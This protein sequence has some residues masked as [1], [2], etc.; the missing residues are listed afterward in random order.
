MCAQRLVA[1]V[2][3]FIG[4]LFFASAASTAETALTV[5]VDQP[6]TKISPTLYGIFFE[7]INRAGEGGL[8][9][10][11]LQNRS[12]E[13]DRG[14]RDQKPVKIPGWSL[15]ESPGAKATI[16]LDHSE[17]LN[18]RDPNSLRLEIAAVGQVPVGVANEGFNGLALVKGASYE[19]SFYARSSQGM[20]GPLVATLED[21]N[22]IVSEAKPIGE[23]GGQWKQYHETLTAKET[24][25]RGRLVLASSSSGTIW[26]DEVSLFPKNTWKGRP[27]GLRPDLAKMLADLKPAFNRFPGGCYVEGNR[28]ANAFRWKNSI[29]ELA[30][31]PGHWNLWGYRSTDGLGYHEYLQLCEDIGAEPLFVINCGMAHED[32]IPND[33]LG[34]WIQDAL[35]AIEYA[36]GPA[37]SPWGSLRAKAGHPASF[38][39]KYMEI[40]NENGGPVYEDHYR[41]FYDAIKAKYPGMILVANTF[42]RTRP[43]DVLDEHYY[44]SPEFFMR[45]AT[46]YD[47]YDRK[48]SPKI[49]VGEYAVT[50]G[51]G[52]GNLRAAVG[53]AAFM[54]GMERN[55][56]IVVMASYAPLF[57]NCGWRQWNPNAINF[58][59]SRAYG[60]PSYHVQKM[61]SSHRGDVVL[62]IDFHAP[63]VKLPTKGGAIGVGTWATQAEFKDIKV[64][65]GDKVLFQSDFSKGLNG[66]RTHQGNWRTRNGSLEQTEI[67]DD[68]RV[69]A[70]DRSWKNY[71]LTL[72]ARKL[73]G[74]EGFLILF[75]VR[76]ENAKSWWNL[77]GW[78][79]TRHGLELDGANAPFVDGHI[80][81]GRWYDIKVENID[82]RIRCYLDGLLVH[83]ARLRSLDSMYAVA[84]RAEKSGEVIL[85]IVNAAAAPQ[86][87]RISLA[88]LNG[89]VKSGTVTVL[90][91]ADP[92]D[93]NSLENPDKVV[94]KES[95]LADAGDNFLHNF[96]GNSVSVIRLTVE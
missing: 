16:N 15:V 47:D 87:V 46:R 71:T 75:N 88:G 4:L 53:E 92:M 42:V 40:G 73:G 27:N 21:Q 76:D 14:D 6:R 9:A 8:Y 44:D 94:P 26:L 36:N 34:P 78:G 35:D 51:C 2:T 59:N 19:L 52:K 23:I 32:S 74:N 18:P 66:W 54:T 77:G 5:H 67:K 1:T 69:V 68:V 28:L 62:G 72:K 33:K 84:S 95:P 60:T 20:R 89:K 48:K 37:D 61:F 38:N 49:Y 83:D 13:D 41:Q 22:G 12:F 81:T 17:P 80:E 56:D 65:Q 39:L 91:S 82:D 24:T 93:E 31:R 50:Q 25:S 85:K 96:P 79:N 55:S 7:E 11:M 45:N 29:G 3:L 43:M 70:G 58:D 90:S 57:V 30:E 64:T 86:D 10:E 63:N